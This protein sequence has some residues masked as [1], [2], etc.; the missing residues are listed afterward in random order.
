[1]GQAVGL[2]PELLMQEYYLRT[3]RSGSER[4]NPTLKSNLKAISEAL[5]YSNFL[6]LMRGVLPE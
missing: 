1:M 5:L 4:Y 6:S 2:G 3:C